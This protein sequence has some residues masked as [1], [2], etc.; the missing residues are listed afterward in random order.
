MT[1]KIS[2][3]RIIPL[4]EHEPFYLQFPAT[5]PAQYR[6]SIAKKGPH[7]HRHVEAPA[8]SNLIP[9]EIVFPVFNGYA[10][11]Q[12]LSG[13]I[14]AHIN[15]LII[16]TAMHNEADEL[17]SFN[18]SG[19]DMPRQDRSTAKPVASDVMLPRHHRKYPTPHEQVVSVSK[20]SSEN[21]LILVAVD[22][23]F[24][25]QNPLEQVLKQ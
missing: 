11:C 19:V 7:A 22:I 9:L 24:A 17:Q 2:S 12:T 13:N 15:R 18:L 1:M 6:V 16:I 25:N 10:A 20:Q 21:H 5:M 14:L 23:F 4:L 8:R 3:K